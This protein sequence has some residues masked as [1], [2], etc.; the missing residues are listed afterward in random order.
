MRT[1]VAGL[2][3]VGAD[4]H[5]LDA[6]TLFEAFHA[7]EIERLGSRAFFRAF[8]RAG[9]STASRNIPGVM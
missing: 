9:S 3:R 7:E 1:S 6:Q 4:M 8:S 5:H 2:V